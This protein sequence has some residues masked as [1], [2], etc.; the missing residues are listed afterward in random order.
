MSKPECRKCPE[1]NAI[2]RCIDN[3]FVVTSLA[4]RYTDK[5]APFLTEALD[6]AINSAYF[7]SSVLIER[8]FILS[9][10]WRTFLEHPPEIWEN[11]IQLLSNDNANHSRIE[12]CSR[13]EVY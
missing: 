3:R 4:K 8:V 5:G 11:E 10:A 12:G 9:Y 13:V 1:K 6:I 2:I 7:F